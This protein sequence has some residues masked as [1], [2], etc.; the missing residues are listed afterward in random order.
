M[1]KY[2][3]IL[4]SF[5]MTFL[6]TF[7]SAQEGEGELFG[8]EGRYQIDGDASSFKFKISNMGLF[9]VD[10]TMGGISGTIDFDKIN[11]EGFVYLSLEVKTIDTGVKKR[12]EH[13]RTSDFFYVEKYPKIEFKGDKLTRIKD[14]LYV[15]AGTLSMRG[16]SLKEKVPIRFEA[17]GKTLEFIG[18]AEIDRT[19]YGV[20]GGSTVGDVAEVTYKIIAK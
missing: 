7:T 18:T 4:M 2:S 12:D 14:N 5:L 3:F 19:K 15:V 16:V 9:S 13:I 8:T 17:S 20:D 6:I 1:Y 11:Q 10:G